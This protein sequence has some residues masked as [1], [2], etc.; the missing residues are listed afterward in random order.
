MPYDEGFATT[1]DGVRLYFQKLGSGPATVIVPNGIYLVD[2][3]KHLAGDRTLIFYDMRNRGRSDSIS[4]PSKLEKG[5]H[6]DV[7]DLD[8]VRRHF[9]IDRVDLIGHSYVGMIVALYAMKHPRH[10][11]RVV[12]IGPIQ[13]DA[14]TQYPA[15]LMCTD[16]TFTEV[17]TKLANLQE[18][19]R[20]GDPQELCKQFWSVLRVLYVAKAAD[21]RKINWGRC[22]L[23]NERDFMKYW[24]GVIL[25]SIRRL[26]LTPGDF[27]K[28]AAP[29]L[30]IH[31]TMDRSA[32]YGGGREWA[33][34]LPEAR[35]VT[36]P[37]AAHAPWI[38]A[39]ERVFGAIRTFLNGAWPEEAEK[40]T[41]L[42][43]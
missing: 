6:N 5:L 21:A 24:I 34:L 35:L 40:V 19:N 7:D 27:A 15:N 3:F 2:D 1:G 41:S 9:T 25:P 31:G 10:V 28:V 26:K 12:Q 38:E 32:P 43:P 22:D 16:A 17:L 39:P 20:S 29:V 42:E 36:V 30:T 14:N 18:Q 11:N 13:P 33:M 4:D 23:P 37:D 8:A